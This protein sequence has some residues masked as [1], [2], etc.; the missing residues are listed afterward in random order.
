M[1]PQSVEPDRVLG[2]VVP[3]SVVG[4]LADRLEGI[5]I[6]GGEAAIDEP[7]CDRRRIAG[8]KLGGL[9]NGAQYAL[10]RDRVLTDVIPIGTEHAAEILRP[11]TVD[12]RAD[13]Y[14]A[15]V[16]G[17]QFLG[18]R[19]KPEEGV[20]LPRREQVERIGLRAGDP[21]D[22]LGRVEADMSGHQAQQRR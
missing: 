10:G 22:I 1:Q 9:E 18:L 21:S 20:D 13:D 4:K 11:W 2:V 15:G 14:M 19:G 12:R 7:P 3:P 8:A 6:A 17:A 5:V 16:A